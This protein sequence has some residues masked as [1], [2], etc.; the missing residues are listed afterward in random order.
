MFNAFK[1]YFSFSKKELNGIL[2]LCIIISVTLLVPVVFSLFQ[3]PEKNE[4]AEFDAEISKFYA[5]MKDGPRYNYRYNPAPEEMEIKAEYFPFNPNNLSGALWKR[6]G[7]TDRQIKVIKN[8]E[9]KGGRFYKKEDLRK[10][11]SITEHDYARLE[12]YIKIDNRFSKTNA[13][14]PP[15]EKPRPFNLAPVA[16][17]EINS[18]DSAQLESL[19]G[20]GPAFA[21]RII[22]Y[23]NRLGGFYT[24]EQLREIYGLDSAKYAGIKEQIRLDASLIQKLNVNTAGFED[25][26]RYPYLSYKQMNA[27]I[28]Y[29]TQHGNYQ[30]IADLQK[31]VLLNGEILR[32]IEPYITF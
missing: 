6:L 26:K 23:R 29:R 8:F 3:D 14:L 27:I 22:R 11:Y 17:V 21:S 18:A 13:S 20:I 25:L 24:K 1:E 12:P 10:I 32:K 31:V 5:S 7:L 9:S 16:V 28:Q 30:S 2:V 19:R 4:F 15:P